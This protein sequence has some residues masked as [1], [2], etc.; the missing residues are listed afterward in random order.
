MKKEELTAL[1]LTEEQANAVYA[2]N[3][4]DVNAVRAELDTANNTIKTLQ[5]T[6]KAF[7]GVD[8]DKLKSAAGDW[9]KKYNDDISALKLNYALESA[10]IGAKARDV[11]AVKPFI[12]MGIVKLDGDKIIGLEEQLKSIRETKGFLFEDEVKTPFRTG[13]RQTGTEGQPDKKEEANE[14][15]RAMF[16]KGE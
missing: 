4:K 5:D 1:G 16:G 7:D 13:T 9:E 10:L 11:K 14:A 12:D 6:V 8:I 2:L 3:G 15:L